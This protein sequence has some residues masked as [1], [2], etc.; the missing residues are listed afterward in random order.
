MLPAEFAPGRDPLHA[1]GAY[2]VQE[3]SAQMPA[4]LF[5]LTPGMA[6]LDVCAAPGSF[7]ERQ[8]RKANSHSLQRSL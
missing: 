3:L 1:A 2:Y 5:D 8:M 4:S 7:S 6:V